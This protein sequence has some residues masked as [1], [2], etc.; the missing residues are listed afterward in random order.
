MQGPVDIIDG[1]LPG[2]PVAFGEPTGVDSF[3]RER[4]RLR[5]GFSGMRFPSVD[6]QERD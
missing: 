5:D 4:V 1:H 3:L 6:G 2:V